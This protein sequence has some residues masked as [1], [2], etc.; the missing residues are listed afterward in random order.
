MSLRPSIFLYAKNTQNLGETGL[1]VP[2]FISMANDQLL[3]PA[4]RAITVGWHRPIEY[5]YGDGG[6]WG[7]ARV[8]AGACARVCMHP[9]V[10]ACV[11]DEQYTIIAIRRRQCVCARVRNLCLQYTIIIFD[12]G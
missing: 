12:P 4:E 7:C 5:R 11:R 9:F 6:V 8:R 1:P 10:R 2:V 3:S